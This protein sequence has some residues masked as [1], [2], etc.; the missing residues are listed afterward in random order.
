[1]KKLKQIQDQIEEKV[2]SDVF[3]Q[4]I[5][6]LKTYLEAM[7]KAGT[8][9]KVNLPPPNTNQSGMPTK[10][11]NKLKELIPKISEL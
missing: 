10:D 1:M 7:H 6:Y 5:V 4:E 3:D 8:G 2:D 9:E 11:I